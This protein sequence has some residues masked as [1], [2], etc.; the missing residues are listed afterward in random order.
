M[1]LSQATVIYLDSNNVS[2]FIYLEDFQR[3]LINVG[4]ATLT[5]TG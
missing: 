4:V 1:H 3:E 2:G 5:Q